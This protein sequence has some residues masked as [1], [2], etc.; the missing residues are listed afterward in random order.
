MLSN[1]NG[2]NDPNGNKNIIC[3]MVKYGDT[4]YDTHISLKYYYLFMFK[5]NGLEVN[6]PYA[7]QNF[8]IFKRRRDV[9]VENKC[10]ETHWQASF[11]GRHKVKI[12]IQKGD[13]EFLDGICGDCVF[14]PGPLKL[15]NGTVLPT[16]LP[17]RVLHHE[18][19]KSYLAP[20]YFETE[21]E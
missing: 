4:F 2:L 10:S 5:V 8:K 16:N 12:T 17:R 15:R 7:T 20:G 21:E 14:P 9:I 1:E 13:E 6:T 3:T 11:D 18:Y 19:G